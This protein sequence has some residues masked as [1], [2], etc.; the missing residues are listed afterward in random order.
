M[1]E[2]TKEQYQAEVLREYANII[3]KGDTKPGAEARAEAEKRVKER[4]SAQQT[5]ANQAND[6][7]KDKIWFTPIEVRKIVLVG[8]VIGVALAL[9]FA[10]FVLII[11]VTR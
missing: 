3:A 4:L 10:I 7:T 1:K 9:L 11:A 8:I 6:T 5:P 2:L